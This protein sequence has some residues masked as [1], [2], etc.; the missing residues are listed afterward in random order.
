[1]SYSRQRE[2]QDSST[3]RLHGKDTVPHS[4]QIFPETFLGILVHKSDLVCSCRLGGFWPF[5]VEPFVYLPHPYFP[6]S[7]FSQMGG[8]GIEA[9]LLNIPSLWSRAA[10]KAAAASRY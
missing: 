9:A 3:Y 8:G 10:S 2:V 5:L 7:F 4:K 1:M 6:K